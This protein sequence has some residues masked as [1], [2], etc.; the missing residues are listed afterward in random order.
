MQVISGVSEDEQVALKAAALVNDGE[1]AQR[2]AEEN[3]RLGRSVIL[4][5]LSCFLS[6]LA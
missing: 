4:S 3:S 2:G 1:A 5:R 6:R